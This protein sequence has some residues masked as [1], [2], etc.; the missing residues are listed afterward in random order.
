MLDGSLALNGIANVVK[1]L[2]VNQP[3]QP[4]AFCKSLDQSFTV[5]VGAQRQVA[6]DA[7]I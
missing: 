3:L 1:M 6:C 2:D 5:F 7:D 4:V